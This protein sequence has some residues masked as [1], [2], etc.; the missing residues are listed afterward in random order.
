MK[1]IILFTL[2]FSMQFI[3]AQSKIYHQEEVDIQPK[4][5]G[6]INNF[7]DF[8]QRNLKLTDKKNSQRIIHVEFIVEITGLLT[9]IK[10]VDPDPKDEASE[11]EVLRI[12]KLSQK[13]SPAAYKGEAVRCHVIQ[14][15]FNPH[16][17]YADFDHLDIT[18]EPEQPIQ[19]STDE[20][21]IYN[22]AGIEK[23]PEFPGGMEK[24]YIFFNKNFKFPENEDEDI[25]GKVFVSFVVEKEGSLSDL[26]V[27]RDIGYG[28][29]KEVIRVL[30]MCPK[31]N[32]G[33]QN[34]KKVR[35]LFT[36]PFSID[37]SKNIDPIKDK[38]SEK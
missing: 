16:N 9:D 27:L 14:S 18:V 5:P 34:G 10:I 7:V 32:P 30:K 8:V 36:M 21:T 1:K 31:W 37:N 19:E 15:V 2:L 11:K 24:F 6:G 3:V 26:K 13:W 23:R 25:K 33:M 35:V 22:S 28:T 12:M 20:N 4:F 38:H 17:D 29:G